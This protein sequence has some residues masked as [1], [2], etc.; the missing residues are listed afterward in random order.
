MVKRAGL[1]TPCC[2]SSGICAVIFLAGTATTDARVEPSP[3][4][5]EINR[6]HSIELNKAAI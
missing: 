1:P 2:G 5:P 4:M 6:I 3:F